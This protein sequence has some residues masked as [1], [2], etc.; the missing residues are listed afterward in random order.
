VTLLLVSTAV[1]RTAAAEDNERGVGF[2]HAA[3]RRVPA[4]FRMPPE[5]TRTVHVMVERSGTFRRQCRRLAKEP[6]LLI[7]VRFDLLLRDRSMRARPVIY[8]AD[9]RPV[10]ALISIGDVASPA[11]WIAH[12]FE[13]L[14]EQLDGPGG[15]AGTGVSGSPRQIRSRA[16]GR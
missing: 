3:A 1:V 14:V 4:T 6:T 12:T 16:S 13:H 15:P 5:I 8:R 11:E 9:S 10:L 2:Y 7:R